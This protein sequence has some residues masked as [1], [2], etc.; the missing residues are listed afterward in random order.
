[1]QPSLCR[2]GELAYIKDPFEVNNIRV[3]GALY[4]LFPR[5]QS[6][7]ESRDRARSTPAALLRKRE[8][9][10]ALPERESVSLR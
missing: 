8:I 6:V 7:S 9:T 5:N 3:I 1:M 10:A 4:L 2:I